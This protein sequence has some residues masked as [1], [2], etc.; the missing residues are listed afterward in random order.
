MDKLHVNFISKNQSPNPRHPLN[1]PET[2][3]S[4]SISCW[5]IPAFNQPFILL[6]SDI[7]RN[8]SISFR[9]QKL[10]VNFH[11]LQNT[12]ASLMN[13]WLFPWDR[14][15]LLYL[16]APCISLAHSSIW[17]MVLFRKA[18][19]WKNFFPNFT[20]VLQF[21]LK[22]FSLVEVFTYTIKWNLHFYYFK[23]QFLFF[24]G[25]RENF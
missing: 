22:F 7:Y 17:L 16:L 25:N 3:W 10:L 18:C 14:T 13:I 11:W 12:L 15:V 21:M 20:W 4:I 2:L 6:P 5:L 8:K 19:F 1:D 9:T 23:A 24:F